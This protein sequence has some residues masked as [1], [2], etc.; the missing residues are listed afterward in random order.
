M[1]EKY[2]LHDNFNS[3]L[4]DSDEVNELIYNIKLKIFFAQY[5]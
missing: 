3:S 5:L 2:E 4:D 1:F